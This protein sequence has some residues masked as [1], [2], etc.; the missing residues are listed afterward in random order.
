[1]A[2]PSD[3]EETTEAP[4]AT[5]EAAEPRAAEGGPDEPN[6]WA[7]VRRLRRTAVVLPVVLGAALLV[8]AGCAGYLVHQQNQLDDLRS[9][10]LSSAKQYC[11]ELATYDYRAVNANLDA[12]TAS[13]TPRFGA[14]Y[15]DV[16]AQLQKLLSDGQGAATGTAER[17]GLVSVD[18][19]R[20]EVLVFLDQDVQNAAVPEGRIDASRMVVTLV[21]QDGRWLLDN[22]EPK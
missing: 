3:T 17:A 5:P 7:R 9:S 1:M 18:T 11:V 14:E 6:R 2:T 16:A 4:A 19:E 13:S 8:A 15:R 21:R 10:A 22:A 12:V 20:A